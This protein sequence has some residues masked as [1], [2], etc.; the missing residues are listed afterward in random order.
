MGQFRDYL[1]NHQP[2]K[3][4]GKKCKVVKYGNLYLYFDKNKWGDFKRDAQTIYGQ[5]KQFRL[6]KS[7]KY[8]Q[9]QKFVALPQADKNKITKISV[10]AFEDVVAVYQNNGWSNV[11]EW[12]A[13]AVVNGYPVYLL[14]KDD[15]KAQ[16]V[17][18]AITNVIIN[19]AD[20][21]P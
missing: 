12:V 6:W 4:K 19:E 7:T 11:V 8:D 21:E 18:T 15:S 10:E 2:C 13:F 14:V 20:A 1:N 3:V 9:I 16:A 17:F 5:G